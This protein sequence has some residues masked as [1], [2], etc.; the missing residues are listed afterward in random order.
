MKDIDRM[1][2]LAGI[3]EAIQ[4]DDPDEV[5]SRDDER[6]HRGQKIERLITLAFKQSDIEIADLY[7]DEEDGRQAQVTLDADQIDVVSLATKLQKTGLAQS[8]VI[9]AS[10]EGLLLIFSVDPGL[11]HAEM[12]PR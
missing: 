3:Q 7:Y 2:R 1:R 12:A 4:V 6:Y 9:A 10:R 11:D 5:E 8:Y